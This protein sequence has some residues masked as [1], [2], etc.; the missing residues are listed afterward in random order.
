MKEILKESIKT[1]YENKDYTEVVRDALLCLT[2]EI[3]KKS[4]LTDSDGVDLIN[5]AFSEKQPLIKINKLETTTDKN[6]HRGIMDLSKGL[7]EYFRNPMSHSKQEYSK[8]VA[9][10]ILVLLDEVILEEIIG[11]KSINSIEDWYLEITNDLFP[12][13]E[14]YAKSLISAIPKNK[15]YELAVMLYKNRNNITKLKDKIIDELVNNLSEEE[16]KDYCEVIENDLFGNITENDVIS[17]LKFITTNIWNKLYDL[18]K[19]KVEDIAKEDI[20][21]LYLDFEYECGNYIPSEQK[22]GYILENSMHILENFSNL[23]DIIDVIVEKATVNSNEFLQDYLFEKY[24]FLIMSK[25]TK[26]HF[27]L[28]D[29]ICDRLRYKNKPM[30]YEIVK[31]SLKQ[32]PKD[33]YWYTSLSEIFGLEMKKVDSF[34][35]FDIDKISTEDLPF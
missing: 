35:N 25:S 29:M 6:K 24:F 31:K 21:N 17:S 10:A 30:W 26:K 12:N 19:S 4:D 16:F 1:H 13:T 33:N 8:K 11:S 34:E 14:R 22:N 32:L 5:K 9:D 15:Y 7:I 23:Q 28:I 18:A 3:R 2:T 27:D 20:S